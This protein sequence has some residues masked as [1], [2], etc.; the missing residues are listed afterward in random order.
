MNNTQLRKA[1][2]SVGMTTFIEYFDY[3]Q[4]DCWSNTDLVELLMSERS[5]TEKSAKTKVVNAR[6]IMKAS[7][8]AEALTI[9][10]NSKKAGLQI[11]SKA[12]EKMTGS[13]NK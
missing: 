3:F 2:Q 11:A 10:A 8:V 12:K 9:I 5:Y 1:I 6:R 4:Q 7:L 13:I